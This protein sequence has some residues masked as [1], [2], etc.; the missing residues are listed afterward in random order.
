M[1][2]PAKAV[3]DE[4]KISDYVDAGGVAAAIL[5][6]HA[7]RAVNLLQNGGY[8]TESELIKTKGTSNGTL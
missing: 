2:Q 6:S 5:S 4:R 7:V 3:Q 1:Y 8:K